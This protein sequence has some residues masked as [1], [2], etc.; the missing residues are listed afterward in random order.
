M[1]RVPDVRGGVYLITVLNVSKTG[2]Q[3]NCPT[4]L[5]AGTRVEIRCRG[6]AI[7]GE[8]R[9]ARDVGTH[10]FHLGILADSAAGATPETG[11]LDLTLLFRG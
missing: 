6:T 11:G 8:V 4:A 7:L 5:A 1:M 10:E 9:Y 2:L 3:I